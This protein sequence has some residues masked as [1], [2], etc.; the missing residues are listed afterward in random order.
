[1]GQVTTDERDGLAERL[2]A[3]A[4]E[5]R[6]RAY[7]PYSHYP[8]GAALLTRAGSVYTGVNVENA[9]Y[10][11]TTCAERTAVVGAVADGETDFVAIAVVTDDGGSPC[12]SCR[13]V[14]REFNRGELRVFI[15]T[16]DG[17]YREYRLSDLL[18]DSF[19]PD[20][21]ARPAM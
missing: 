18:P 19:G 21:L 14:L 15:A 12:G 3:Q 20:N 4:A 10:P 8:V 5:A 6:R 13:Q 17:R 11:L 7:V 2:I 16:P 1:M 9:V